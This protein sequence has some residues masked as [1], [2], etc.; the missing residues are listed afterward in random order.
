MAL[1][2]R[3]PLRLGGV[4]ALG[5][6]LGPAPRRRS[7]E[8][9]PG[10]IPRAGASRQPLAVGLG[11]GEADDPALVRAGGC[12]AKTVKPERPEPGAGSVPGGN[13]ASLSFPFPGC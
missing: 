12:Q 6:A 3:T 13:I 2:T 10:N 8:Y 7:G 4:G 9:S 1:C 11:S 5:S